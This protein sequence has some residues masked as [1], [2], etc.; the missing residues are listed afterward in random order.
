MENIVLI[1]TEKFDEFEINKIKNIIDSVAEK[2]DK[3]FGLDTLNEFKV[4]FQPKEKGGEQHL[5]EVIV[6]ADTKFGK[7]RIEKQDYDVMNIMDEIKNE[8]ERMIIDKKDKIKSKRKQPD[9]A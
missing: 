1:G 5:F 4:V 7:M 8:L 2:Y 9:N 6:S 3:I